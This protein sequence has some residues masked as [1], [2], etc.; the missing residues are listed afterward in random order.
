MSAFRLMWHS[1]AVWGRGVYAY[2]S[3]LSFEGVLALNAGLQ[4]AFAMSVLAAMCSHVE[5]LAPM[6]LV[7]ER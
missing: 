3:K 2:R 5:E 1:A 6:F 7:I 4:E